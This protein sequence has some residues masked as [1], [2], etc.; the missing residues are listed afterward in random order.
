[1][2]PSDHQDKDAIF[3]RR[4]CRSISRIDA[5]SKCEKDGA[6]LSEYFG[7]L[8]DSLLLDRIE[9]DAKMI[10]EMVKPRSQLAP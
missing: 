4:I 9:A 8:K 10:R 2:P 7:A 5:D 3:D 1:M 6:D